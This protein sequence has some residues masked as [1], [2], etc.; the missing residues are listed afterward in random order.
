M[1]IPPIII[2]EQQFNDA[3]GH[4]YAGG[5]LATYVR[6]TTTPKQTWLDPGQAALNTNPVILDAAGRCLLWGDGDYRLILRDAAGNLIWDI[7]ATSLVSAAMYPVVSAPTIADAVHLLGLDDTVTA[8][9][10]ASAI[11]TE[12]AARIAADNAEIAARTAADANLQSQID[13]INAMIGGLP[14]PTAVPLIQFSHEVSDA[15]GHHRVT[16]PVAYA[17]APPIAIG[18]GGPGY[19][20]ASHTVVTDATGFDIWWAFPEVSGPVPEGVTSYY[21]IATGQRA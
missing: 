12:Q 11:S 20:I 16:F 4:P 8:A 1:T 2:P 17:S 15:D 14:G 13:A 9:E 21:Y 6:G 10:L 7:A 18:R 5:S 3:D 19:D